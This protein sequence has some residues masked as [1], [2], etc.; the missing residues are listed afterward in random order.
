[1]AIH[2][3]YE[4]QDVANAGQRYTLKCVNQS[5]R[6]WVFYVY[7]KLPD[8]TSEIFSLAW[9]ASPYKIKPNDYIKF[10]WYINYN[11]VWSDTGKLQPG[12]IFEAGGA[13]DANLDTQNSTTF[14][15]ENGAPGL[16]TPTGD[17]SNKGTLVIT[18]L[19]NIPDNKFSVGIGM[20]GYGTY[21]TQAGPNLNHL[22]T[23]TPYYWVAAGDEMEVGKVLKIDTV[24]RT[25]EIEYPKN[26]Y[27]IIATLG[28]DYTWSM[29]YSQA[30]LGLG[31]STISVYKHGTN[32]KLGSGLGTIDKSAQT[33]TINQWNDRPGLQANTK[34]KLISDGKTYSD[35][36]TG[37]NLNLPVIFTGVV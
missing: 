14:G 9:F 26:V 20:S 4:P 3:S 25:A 1:M 30:L 23:P 19:D 13:Q 32:T 37:N 18:D 34:Y 28:A 2:I 24:T 12:I 31:L 10:T 7:Q 15:Y 11:F 6:N 21:V 22:F 29:S 17:S 33:A 5:G 35:V 36:S 8:I 27:D 16:S